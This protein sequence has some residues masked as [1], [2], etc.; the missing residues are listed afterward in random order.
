MTL[1][2]ENEITLSLISI[3]FIMISGIWKNATIVIPTETAAI[4]VILMVRMINIVITVLNVIIWKIRS[5][6]EE[7]FVDINKTHRHT[8]AHTHI[9]YSNQNGKDTIECNFDRSIILVLIEKN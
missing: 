7:K 5:F 6:I 9:I 1:R 8:H 3:I 4:T 2:H